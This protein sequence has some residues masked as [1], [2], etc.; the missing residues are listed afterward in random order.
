MADS[1]HDTTNQAGL[2]LAVAGG[3]TGGHLFPGIAV[4][5]A[6]MLRNAA[7][8]V[9]FVNAGRP[10]ET[11]VLARLG[12]AHAVIPI[13]GIKGRGWW[14]QTM[15]AFK[16]PRA[17]LCARSAL[18]SFK[19][20]AVLGVGG[21]SAG[22]VVTAAWLMG[23]P[24][25][26]H[27][28]NRIPGV[29][30][31]M[32]SRI[33]DRIYVSFEA[34]RE[35]FDSAKV[36]ISGNP[37]REEIVRLGRQFGQDSASD[38]FNVLVVGGSQGA[39]AVNRAVVEALPLLRNARGLR[40]VHQTGAQDEGWV[41]QAYTQTGI[42]AEVKSF[43]NDMAARYQQSD[44]VIC[45]AGATTVAELTA[46]G[47]AAVFVPFPFATDDHQTRNAEALVT[48]G[49]A[50]LIPQGELTGQRLADTVSGCMQDRVQLRIMAEKAREL[51]RPEA[52]E[53]IVDDLYVLMGRKEENYPR[54]PLQ[55][56]G[57]PDIDMTSQ[58]AGR[59]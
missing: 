30:N 32:L 38:R 52:A 33:V 35:H 13:E 37:V 48:A 58:G 27:E 34:G 40:F 26:L 44:L 7:N 6:F 42:A 50:R 51:G 10:L 24:T 15:A 45:R 39:Q 17:V 19:A 14:R 4:A 57:D 28:Q 47:R 55:K 29:T 43:F 2:S 21:Y 20:D 36:T 8:R 49:A 9:L 53:T 46:V 1:R 56:G 3:G 5:Q 31:R 23:L 25:A 59:N 22:P 16:I 11:Q 12:W 41:Q 54:P 18:R